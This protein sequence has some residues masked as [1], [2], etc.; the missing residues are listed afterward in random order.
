MT[1]AL[2]GADGQ[3]GTDLT[4]LI[5]PGRLAALTYPECDVTRPGRLRR[6]L[7]SLRPSIVI[8]TAAYHRVDECEDEPL[9]ALRVNALA[10]RDLA[11]ACRE[12]DAVLVHFSTDYVFDGLRREPYVEE[13]APHPLNAYG[14]SK[15]A[16][17]HFLRSLWPKHFVL[18]TC[19]LFGE[20][21]SKEKGTN[22][23]ESMIAGARGGRTL[24]V[25]S[26]QIVTPTATAELAPRVLALAETGAFGLYHMTNEGRCTWFEFAR[27]VFEILGLQPDLR[28][29]TSEVFGARARRPCFSV[30][31]NR[32]YNRLS[33]PP[34]S[35]WRN[36]LESY[37]RLKGHLS[38]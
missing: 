26:D 2:I 28:P 27:A 18:R 9:T 32:A 34:F 6:T 19:G 16:G 4:K 23:V 14:V 38:G 24:R 25:V 7:E 22:F 1:I 3:L 20:A 37:L 21:G 13:D 29:V 12:L 17:E 15:L 36:A 33:L 31:E 30:L 35:H 5:P 10:V 8:N 11:L